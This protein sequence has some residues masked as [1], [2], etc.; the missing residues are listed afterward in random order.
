MFI[1][2]I[3]SKIYIGCE[4]NESYHVIF[5]IILS[6]RLISVSLPNFVDCVMPE[7]RDFHM[8]VYKLNPITKIDFILIIGLRG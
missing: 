5:T 3:M 2:M 7:R 8:S 4:E 6:N 1:S